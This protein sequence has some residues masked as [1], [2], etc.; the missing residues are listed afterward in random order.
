MPPTKE[1]KIM[2]WV[3]T[4]MLSLIT[5][6]IISGVGTLRRMEVLVA[7]HEKAFE[8][9]AREHASYEIRLGT[10]QNKQ[11]NQEGRLIKMEAILP[12]LLYKKKGR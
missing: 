7:N 10:L 3:Q 11:D 8:Y 12:E 9:N 4:I 2:H 1:N 6:A 5:A